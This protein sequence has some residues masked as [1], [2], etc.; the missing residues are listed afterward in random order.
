MLLSS[1]KVWSQQR[2]KQNSSRENYHQKKAETV[3]CALLW[4]NSHCTAL[5][6]GP[7]RSSRTLRHQHF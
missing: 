4:R 2:Q 5:I 3:H 6:E 7:V 1:V